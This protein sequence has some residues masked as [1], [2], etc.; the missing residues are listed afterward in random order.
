MAVCCVEIESVR[1][2]VKVAEWE[3]LESSKISSWSKEQVERFS[4]LGKPVAES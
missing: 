3:V 2:I 4:Y 1:Y